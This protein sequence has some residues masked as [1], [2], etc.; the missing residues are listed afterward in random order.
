MAGTVAR[1]VYIAVTEHEVDL[2]V[3]L[4]GAH[5][6]F[7]GHL[8]TTY[9]AS[10]RE[11]FTY[12]PVAAL[13]FIPLRALSQTGAQVAWAVVSVIVLVIFL[14]V[15][16]HAIR[17]DWSPIDVALAALVLTFPVAVLNPIAM[18]FSF[19]QINLL[20]A[21]LVLA[22][23]TG[24]Y[25]I[26]GHQLPRGL[27]TGLA[28]ALKVT[29]LIFVLFLFI[30]RQIRAGCVALGTFVACGIGMTIVVPSESRSYWTRY[31][32]DAHRVGG[33]VFISNQS[34]RSAIVRFTHAHA[35]QSLIVVAILFAGGVGLWVAAWAYR[36]SSVVLGVL[37]C[38]VTGLIV[39]PITWSHHLV[40][41]AP[42]V[43][44]LSLADDRPAFGRCWA[45]LAV[46]WFWYGVIWRTPHGNGIELRDSF[47][48][49]LL[50]NSY[51]L[52]M[53]LF[54][55][56]IAA[57]LVTRRG[58]RIGGSRPLSDKRWLFS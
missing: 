2:G 57:M 17:P 37:V 32:F 49:M 15:S 10:P 21:L 31:I 9:V 42:I 55:I 24:R 33:V 25:S 18:T 35:P 47:G 34:L 43:L 41:V 20:L 54:V 40:W 13:F 51:T 38:A 27:M 3:Y 6:I 29:P 14:A 53:I 58:V 52:G 7:T 5:Q 8:Y 1:V 39:S 36:T 50:G 28:A 30:T 4:M 45:A 26:A 46:V 12:P 11:P 56:G 19:G 16:L 44:W 48:Q 22:D 23:L